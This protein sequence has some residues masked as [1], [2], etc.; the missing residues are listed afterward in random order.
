MFSRNI[1]INVSHDNDSNDP[2]V[3]H[4]LRS[5]AVDIG[6]ERRGVRENHRALGDERTLPGLTDIAGVEIE[7]LV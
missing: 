7:H 6:L 4:T 1:M 2:P 3:P 5:E